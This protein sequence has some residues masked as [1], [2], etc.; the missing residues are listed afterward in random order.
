[1]FHFYLSAILYF[2]FC[3]CVLIADFNGIVTIADRDY[4]SG[5]IS[6]KFLFF[7]VT[8]FFWPVY[9]TGCLYY[10]NR[11]LYFLAFE[12]TCVFVLTAYC[13]ILIL[14]LWLSLVY[15]YPEANIY[16]FIILV[17]EN[18]LNI[19]LLTAITLFCRHGR[20]LVYRKGFYF[21]GWKEFTF[22]HFQMYLFGYLLGLSYFPI[23]FTFCWIWPV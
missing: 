6:N 12:V 20:T 22:M 7:A 1:M 3:C 13:Y 8:L 5:I 2:F 17:D 9:L 18:S 11:F 15:P 14:P 23:F 16:L 19:Y 4:A 10:G 21:D